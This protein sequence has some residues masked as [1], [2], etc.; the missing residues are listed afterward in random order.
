MAQTKN[1]N[2]AIAGGGIAGLTLAIALHHRGIPVIVYEQAAAFSEIGAGVSFSPNA[3]EAMRVCHPG[4]YEVFEKVCTRNLWPSKRNVWFDYLE[5]YGS[6]DDT[7]GASQQSA[8]SISNSLGHNG[9]HRA[10]FLDGLVELFPK[11]ISR[12]GKTLSDIKVDGR[13]EKLVF[14]FTDGST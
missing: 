1:F 13:T 12:F 5:G 3:V 14:S 11:E 4:I 2:V 8:F 10:H 9:V 7:A 6:Y